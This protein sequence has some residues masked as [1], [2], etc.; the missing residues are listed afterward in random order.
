[1]E[2]FQRE[3]YYNKYIIVTREE[4]FSL[5]NVVKYKHKT[6]VERL[7]HYIHAIY[8]EMLCIQA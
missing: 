4:T 3:G 8:N 7:E 1:M 2:S 5:Y 6:Y